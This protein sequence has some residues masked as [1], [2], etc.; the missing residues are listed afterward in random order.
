M[1]ENK[2]IEEQVVRVLEDS[3][4]NQEI[5]IKLMEQE[6]KR[7]EVELKYAKHNA[8]PVKVRKCFDATKGY[9]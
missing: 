4:I 9:E 2:W 7:T 8:K 6:L 5:S 1:N 3:K